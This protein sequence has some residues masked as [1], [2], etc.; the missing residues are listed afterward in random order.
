MKRAFD[1]KDGEVID[2]T[3]ES[4]DS[5]VNAKKV[6]ISRETSQKPSTSKSSE[7]QNKPQKINSRPL[8]ESKKQSGSFSKNQNVR[9]SREQQWIKM[10]WNPNN[11]QRQ[12]GSSGGE[13]GSYWS[14]Y[15][16]VW[17]EH[18][19][20]IGVGLSLIAYIQYSRIR[21]RKVEVRTDE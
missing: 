10:G 8:S 3:N 21:K 19:L 4:E 12:S 13:K 7:V 1:N 18:P 20:P 17:K 2:L 9:N 6:K 16:S 5:P 15:R 11:R 14:Q